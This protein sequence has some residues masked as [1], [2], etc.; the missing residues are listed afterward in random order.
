MER[1][2]SGGI[3]SGLASGEGI[4]CKFTGTYAILNH[5][6][7]SVL[8]EGAGPGSV[9]MQT[10]NAAALAAFLGQAQVL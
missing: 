6:E 7:T 2:A 8:I 3:V 5:V 1:V 4:V 9:Y 10:R